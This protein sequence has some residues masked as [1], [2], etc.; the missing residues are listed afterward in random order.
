MR[1]H[2]KIQRLFILSFSFIIG[3]NMHCV[4]YEIV[5]SFPFFSFFGRFT[6]TVFDSHIFDLSGWTTCS[7]PLRITRSSSVSLCSSTMIR[8]VEVVNP[9]TATSIRDHLCVIRNQ[10]EIKRRIARAIETAFLLND[11]VS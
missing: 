6:V 5:F 2:N 9:L 10:R 4:D 7:E 1:S 11:T 3:V 8:L